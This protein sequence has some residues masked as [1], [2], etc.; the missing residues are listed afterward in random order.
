[1]VASSGS[2]KFVEPVT[3]ECHHTSKVANVVL[4]EGVLPVVRFFL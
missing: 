3:A 1:M 2:K 4:I